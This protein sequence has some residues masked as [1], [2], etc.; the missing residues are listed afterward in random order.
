MGTKVKQGVANGRM[1]AAQV[2]GGVNCH[3]HS[4]VLQEF[5]KLNSVEARAAFAD[6]WIRLASRSM[7]ETWVAYYE[8]LEIIRDQA[9]YADPSYME[10]RQPR[11]SFEDYW[12]EVVQKPF[13][14]WLELEDTY[15]FVREHAPEL[16]EKTFG[17]ANGFRKGQF[18]SQVSTGD[19]LP[20]GNPSGSNQYGNKEEIRNLRISSQGDR[21]R[22]NGVSKRTQEKIDRLARD[23][24]ALHERVKSGEMSVN[25]ASIEAG[26]VRRTL[27]VS[28]DDP[29]A[30]ARQLARHYGLEALRRALAELDG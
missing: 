26:I 28:A 7:D 14:T 5:K 20:R 9:L 19:V 17:E 2:G 25:A 23:F 22:E 8:L 3:R 15:H 24:P 10:D 4:E 29:V 30:A 13:S 16:M 11:A 27:T 6:K 21:S 12:I 18:A 1:W